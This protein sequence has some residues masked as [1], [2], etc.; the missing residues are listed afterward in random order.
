MDDGNG[1][2][3]KIDLQAQYTCKFPLLNNLRRIIVLL[4]TEYW[5]PRDRIYSKKESQSLS[6][7]F[8]LL[9]SV[10]AVQPISS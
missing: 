10:Q 8:T 4:I 1:K 9:N 2:L 6:T 7:T 5:L 3:W